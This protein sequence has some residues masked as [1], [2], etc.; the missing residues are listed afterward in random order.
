MHVADTALA[1]QL[2]LALEIWRA[3]AAQHALQNAVRGLRDD[4]RGLDARRLDAATRTALTTLQQ[5][6]DSLVRAAGGVGGGELAGL[7]TVVESA[8][9]E[10]TAQA[11][12]A[13]A[14]VQAR[15]ARAGR[16][17]QEVQ[18]TELPALNARLQ[19]R[20]LAPLRAAP[21]KPEPPP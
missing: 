16:R 19:Q 2:R 5:A 11:R 7:E 14:E 1:A 21:G 17:W 4:L 15:L 18:T 3:M 12:E 8:D 9:R 6:V 13:F 10:P 20:G